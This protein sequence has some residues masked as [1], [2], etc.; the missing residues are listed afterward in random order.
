MPE[1]PPAPS[2]NKVDGQ[3]PVAQVEFEDGTYAAVVE[4]S[5]DNKKGEVHVKQW[6]PSTGSEP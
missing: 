6:E 5:F 4:L 1:K 2:N 3:H